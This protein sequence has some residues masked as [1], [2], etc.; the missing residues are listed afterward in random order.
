MPH[1]TTVLQWNMLQ[2]LRSFLQSSEP[3]RKAW[4]KG[5]PYAS[6]PEETQEWAPHLVHWQKMIRAKHFR[7][8]FPPLPQ[9]GQL[10]WLESTPFWTTYWKSFQ[11]HCN[12][13]A[14]FAQDDDLRMRMVH[15]VVLH[16]A[17]SGNRH[18]FDTA[19]QAGKMAL[20]TVLQCLS[21]GN[22]PVYHGAVLDW[23]ETKEPR[24]RQAIF[25]RQHDHWVHLPWEKTMKESIFGVPGRH[26][27]MEYLLDLVADGFARWPLTPVEK[28][29]ALAHIFL[30]CP[31]RWH[32]PNLPQGPFIQRVQERLG[33]ALL[34]GV[35]VQAIVLV[36]AMGPNAPRVLKGIK[37][38]A[39]H[40]RDY[41]GKDLLPSGVEELHV[42]ESLY[43]I[44]TPQELHDAIVACRVHRTDAPPPVLSY[45]LPDLDLP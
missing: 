16:A 23:L 35:D 27:K 22:Q 20:A 18:F 9:H 42:L 2:L 7:E 34:N 8:V 39:E 4:R 44:T 28:T 13:N 10:G 25:T 1:C 33:P 38:M 41:P 31:R 15:Q 6:S 32:K 43:T 30:S 19:E 24:I 11:T 12:N 36:C 21:N 26:C 5:E 29:K 3:A 45:E 37:K 17:I 14:A 40:L